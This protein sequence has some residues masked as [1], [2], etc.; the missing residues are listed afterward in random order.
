MTIPISESLTG[1]DYSLNMPDKISFCPTGALLE[2]FR[3]D[4]ER[5]KSSFIY[6]NPLDFDVLIQR[7]H[8]LQT[9]FRQISG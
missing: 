2:R 8:E 6:G 1:V 3:N 7:L 4:Y 5:M 9:R